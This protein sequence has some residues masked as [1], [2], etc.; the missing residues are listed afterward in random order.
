M[1]NTT[2]ELY[3]DGKKSLETLLREKAYSDMQ[4]DLKEKGIDINSV[5]DED[6]ENLVAAKAQD[7]MN[8]IKGFGIGT[9]F[10]IAISLL[11]GV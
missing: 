8:G 9:A 6:V 11:T 10:A 1:I 7:M 5:S 3:N 2:K 4:E